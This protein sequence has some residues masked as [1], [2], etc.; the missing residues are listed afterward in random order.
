ME[1]EL[2]FAL[3]LLR[4]SRE[5]LRLKMLL[6][7]PNTSEEND[8]CIATRGQVIYTDGACP[9]NGCGA[10]HA[11]MGV[12]FGDGDNRNISAKLMLPNPTNNRAELMAILLALEACNST[13]IEICTDSQ[14]S[15]SALTKWIVNWKK[16]NW[17]T[18]SGTPVKNKEILTR[19]D[20]ELSKNRIVEFR[21]V[22]NNNH[23][24]PKN[25][26]N[27]DHYGNYMADKLANEALLH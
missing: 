11:G 16:N 5:E 13:H 21:H 22:S 7:N 24:K 18:A 3:K 2:T 6:H 14:Y 10:K 23:K 12:F 20:K 9:N 25:K 26:K 17:K 15:I 27:K 4:L 8:E 19:L 1:R